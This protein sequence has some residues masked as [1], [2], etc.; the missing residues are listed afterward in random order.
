MDHLREWKASGVNEELTHLNVVSLEGNS[1]TEYLLYSNSIPRRNDGR[2]SEGFLQRYAHT[3]AGG[4]W[5]SGI[6]VLSGQEDIWGCFKPDRPRNSCDKLIKYEHPPKAATGL[7]AL[8]VPL[9]LWQN[10]ADSAKTTIA[11]EDIKSECADMGFWQWLIDRPEVPLC[12]T[13]GAKKAGALLSAGYATVALPGINNGYRTPK[14]SSGKRIG[15]SHLIPQLAKL[16]T[17]G[18][19][20]YLVFDQDSKPKTVKA[21]NAAIKKTGYLLQKAGCQVKVV[22]WKSSLGKGAD[23]LIA[24]HGQGCFTQAYEDGLDLETWKAKL[25]QT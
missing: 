13:E 6:D 20:V 24:N 23:D 5:C 21:V 22:T 7:F 3:D 17:P 19:T 4:W 2:I 16:A 9:D 25:G 18:R 15:K 10:I 8:K 14:D 1:P 11:I 12:I